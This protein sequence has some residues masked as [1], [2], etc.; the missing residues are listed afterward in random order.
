MPTKLDDCIGFLKYDGEQIKDGI[1]DARDAATALL[2]FDRSLRYFISR[3]D[4]ALA[5]LD[6]KIPVKVEHG[7]WSALIPNTVGTWVLAGLGLAATAYITTA[8]NKLAEND[9]K[10]KRLKDV[11]TD[12]L[13]AIQ[14]IIRIG[15]HLGSLTNKRLV[16]LRWRNE[17]T[18]VGI[19][20]EKMEYIFVPRSYF[21]AFLESP[22]SILSD[23]SSLIEVE[24]SLQIGVIENK[25]VI[26][27]ESVSLSERHIF[28]IQKDETEEVLFPHLTHGLSV[29]LDGLVT[30]GNEVA[31]SIGFRYNEHILTCYPRLGSV[32]RFKKHLFLPC[33]IS[34][35][36]SRSDGKGGTNDPRPKIVFDSLDILSEEP[37]ETDLFP[38]DE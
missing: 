10:D 34:G 12:G 38:E 32:V 3:E 5:Q 30:R 14:W 27:I 4:R 21:Q 24:R 11:F 26:K 25:D 17:N 13:K 8:A 33:R 20:N 19:P 31:N 29:D 6:Y 23:I 36:I 2:G 1:L 28:Y 15:K 37:Q 7:S 35:T 16:G 22:S 18:E 9:F